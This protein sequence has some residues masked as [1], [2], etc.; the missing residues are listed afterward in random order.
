[1][2]AHTT[3]LIGFQAAGDLVLRLKPRPGEGLATF[4]EL[5]WDSSAHRAAP[6]NGHFPR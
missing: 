2:P 5:V 4:S 3:I 6:V 1:M